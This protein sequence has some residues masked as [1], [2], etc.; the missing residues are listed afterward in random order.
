MKIFITGGSGFIGRNLKEA[1]AGTYKIVAPSSTELDLCDGDKVAAFLKSHKFDTVIHAATWNA[2]N[3]STKDT[4]RVLEKN[5]RM[6]FNLARCKNDFGKM[7][8]FGSGAEFSREN[9]I[10]MMSEEYFDNH[11]PTDQYGFSK[12]VMAKYAE[13]EENIYN[14]RL[15]GVFGKYEDWQIRFISNACAR[16]AHDLPI[17]IRQNVFFDYLYIDDLVKIVKLFIDRAVKAKTY[18]VCTGRAVDLYTL[19]TQV[20]AVSGKKLDILVVKEGLGREYSGNNSKLLQEIGEFHFRA[21][22]SCIAELY[23]WYVSQIS[24]IDMK[25]LIAEQRSGDVCVRPVFPIGRRTNISSNTQ[26]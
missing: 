3:T 22:A 21:M 18:N 11:V 23:E 13:K 1:L 15:F 6:F 25:K 14:L 16:A 17:I 8:F 5:L 12:Y 24:A 20:L 7:I 4:T 2:T 10:P 19:A 26:I 9:W